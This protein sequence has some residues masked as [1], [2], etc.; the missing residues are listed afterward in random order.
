MRRSDKAI[1]FI[2]ALLAATMLLLAALPQYQPPLTFYPQLGLRQQHGWQWFS[3]HLL[4]LSPAHLLANLF[5]GLLLTLLAIRRQQLVTLLPVLLLSMLAV[6]L[7]L[8]L[9]ASVSWYVGLSGALHGLFAWLMLAR[10]PQQPRWPML[11]AWLLGGVKIYFELQADHSWLGIRTVPQAHL[12][13]YLCGSLLAL[14]SY[15]LRGR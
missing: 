15:A 9:Q 3:A 7:G 4:H 8:V 1:L 13:G 11:L 5:A 10:S 12:Y 2:L 6:D 14:L